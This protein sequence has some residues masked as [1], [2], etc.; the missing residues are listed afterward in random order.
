MILS[1]R[2]V[3]LHRYGRQSGRVRVEACLP[4]AC[5]GIPL[6][7]THIGPDDHNPILSKNAPTSDLRILGA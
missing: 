6:A 4:S 7:G 3:V 2:T 1:G 5:P